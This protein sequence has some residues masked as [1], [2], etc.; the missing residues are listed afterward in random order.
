MCFAPSVAGMVVW[1]TSPV[2]ASASAKTNVIDLIDSPSNPFP[3]EGQ[4][5]AHTWDAADYFRFPGLQDVSGLPKEIPRPLAVFFQ[6]T[7]SLAIVC[8]K[9]HLTD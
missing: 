7:R 2:E 5:L 6:Q 9:K 1:A 4:I 3:G 8:S